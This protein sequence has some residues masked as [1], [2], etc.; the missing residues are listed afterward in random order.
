MIVRV[1]R[2]RLKVSISQ[3]K[4]ATLYS[5]GKIQSLSAK[6]GLNHEL[7]N[8]LKKVRRLMNVMQLSYPLNPI[9]ETPIIH[10]ITDIIR[11][12]KYGKCQYQ[13]SMP[14]LKSVSSNVNTISNKPWRASQ[15]LK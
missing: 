7:P 2:S 13:P 11:G 15:V 8:R 10:Q 6:S 14:I 4:K 12:N 3:P 5:A 9:P 1:D